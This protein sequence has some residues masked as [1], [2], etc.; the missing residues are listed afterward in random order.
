MTAQPSAAV[1]PMH[2]AEGQRQQQLQ[3]QEL[4]LQVTP[5]WRH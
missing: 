1:R 4:G 5:C 3:Q 2:T